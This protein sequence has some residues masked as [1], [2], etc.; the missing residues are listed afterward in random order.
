MVLKDGM[1]LDY[2]GE[3]KNVHIDFAFVTCDDLPD[4]VF[5]KLSD[6]PKQSLAPGE[7]ITFSL[8]F[9]YWGP[10]AKNVQKS[11]L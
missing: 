4:D 6:V 9:T 2:I 8:A 11:M 7:I 10:I 1:P 3:V 5:V